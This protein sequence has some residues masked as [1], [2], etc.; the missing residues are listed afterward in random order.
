MLQ[1]NFHHIFKFSSL[2]EPTLPIDFKY[3]LVGIQGKKVDALSTKERLIPCL[4]L[5]SS[6]EQT[7]IKK[8]VRHKINKAAVTID[9]T[10]C[11]TSLKWVKMCFWRIK[12]GWTD[13]VV[14]FNLNGLVHSH[15]IQYEIRAKVASDET[16]SKCNRRAIAW[17]WKSRSSKFSE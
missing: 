1:Q 2:W 7:Y 5:R 15:F 12:E 16:P 10:K 8:L 9:V 11:L 13:K 17:H 6:W 14:K 3:S 4:Q